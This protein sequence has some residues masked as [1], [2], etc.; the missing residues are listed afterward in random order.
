MYNQING[1]IKQDKSAMQVRDDMGAKEAG[2]R[3]D[4]E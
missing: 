1:K 3:R 2:V 4:I